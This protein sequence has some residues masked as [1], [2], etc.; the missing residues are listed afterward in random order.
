[1]M[2][3]DDFFLKADSQY[4]LGNFDAAFR[5]FLKAAEQGSSSAMSRIACMYGNGE[6]IGQDYGKSLEWDLKAVKFGEDSSMLNLAITYRMVGDIKKAKHWFEKSLASGNGEA[7]LALAKLFMVSD[8]EE[9]NIKY[10]LSIA[11]KHTNLSDQSRN[12]SHAFLAEL[13]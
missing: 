9:E 12:E 8:K 13:K 2:G 10:Y 4:E 11:V 1:M 6:G 3:S 7:A 5:L